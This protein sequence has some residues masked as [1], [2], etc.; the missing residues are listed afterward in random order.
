MVIPSLFISHDPKR[1]MSINLET[2]LWQCFKSGNKGNFIQL[3]AQLTGI[4]FREAYKKFLVEAFFSEPSEEPKAPESPSQED[5]DAEFSNFKLLDVDCN[6]C[7]YN[8]EA[9]LFLISRGLVNQ[10]PFYYCDTG[11]YAGRMI[12]PY[13]HEDRCIFFQGRAL[14]TEL[15]PKYLNYR[16][17]KSSHILYPFDYQSTEPLYVCE[18]VFDA[19]S[20]R[21]LGYN[22]TTTTSCYVSHQQISQLKFYQGP[23][24]V[25]YDT[26]E[27]GLKGLRNFEMIR[28]R[29]RMSKIYYAHPPK[30]HKDWNE[31]YVANADLVHQACRD[32]K[33]FNLNEWDTMKELDTL[34]L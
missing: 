11:L 7:V 33:Q 21:A 6:G 23:V 26:D 5:I 10:G 20:L 17:V 15:Q 3:Y 8:S 30:P 29:N 9:V 16:G 12:I 27:A 31:A 4:S 25:A 13:L 34:G 2:G 22:A 19:L 1:H 28:R 14:N 18:G 32:Y 24:V